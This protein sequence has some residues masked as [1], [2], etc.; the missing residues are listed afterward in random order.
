MKLKIVHIVDYLMPKMGYQ[1]LLLPKWNAKHDHD[2]HII[3]SD[4]FFPVPHYDQTW[5]KLLG[6]RICGTG[7]SDLN[8]VTIHRLPCAWEWKGRTWMSGLE[9]EIVNISPDVIFCHASGS[10]TA[11]RVALFSEKHGLPLLMDNHMLDIAKNTKL[12]GRI[13]YSILKLATKLILL[14]RV[15]R[16]LGVAEECCDFLEIEQGIPK[17]LIA[18]LPLGVDTDVLM[19]ED[20]AGSELRVRFNIPARAKVVLQTGKLSSDKG[21]HLLS[22]AIAPLMK[23]DSDIWLV[24]LGAGDSTY[25]KMVFKPLDEHG[26]MERVM[27]IPLVPFADI[28]KYYSMSDL[29]VYPKAASMSCLEAAACERCVIMTDLPA[30]KWRAEK[31]VG[32]CFRNE[33]VDELRV[34]IRRMINDNDG[35]VKIGKQARVS[36]LENFSY[37][38]IAKQSEELMYQAVCSKKKVSK[39]S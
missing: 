30:N 10:P 21:P 12:N 4:R 36:V 7:V 6:P 9:N 2:V 23:D 14:K 22:Q 24:F 19:N 38:K 37:D 17:H 25:L 39:F 33:D 34:V 13:F 15:Y 31:G 3:T 5:G 18:L 16:F 1:E 28:A 8:N 32:L 11:M 26:V 35:R 20:V 29:C 27:I